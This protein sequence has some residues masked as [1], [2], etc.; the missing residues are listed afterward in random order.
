MKLDG[1]TFEGVVLECG[2]RAGD[3]ETITFRN[4][5]FHSSACKQ[6]GYGDGAYKISTAQDGVAFECET[7]SPQYGKLLWKG[8]VRGRRLDG[9]LTMMKDGKPAAEKWVIAGEAA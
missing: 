1:R 5:R 6:Y 7:E 4:G 9:T 2:K 3:E 8:V